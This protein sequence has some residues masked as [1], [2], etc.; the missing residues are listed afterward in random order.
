MSCSCKKLSGLEQKL[1]AFLLHM[2]SLSSSVLYSTGTVSSCHRS[3]Q[4]EVLLELDEDVDR[5]L[6]LLRFF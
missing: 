3:T 1:T 2:Q 4:S 5:F 6:L